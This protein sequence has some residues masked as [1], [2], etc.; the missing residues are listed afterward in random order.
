MKPTPLIAAML[1]VLVLGAGGCASL[2]PFSKKA[3]E[4]VFPEDE[5]I[6]LDTRKSLAE[7]RMGF[8]QRAFDDPAVEE[9]LG[10]EVISVDIIAN[11]SLGSDRWMG[12]GGS[13]GMESF[14]LTAIGADGAEARI[15][16]TAENRGHGW[17]ATGWRVR[18]A[19]APA[20]QEGFD[21]EEELSIPDPADAVEPA[22]EY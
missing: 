13:R 6:R 4:E 15:D 3:D 18:P 17:E 1:A 7:V 20:A 9:L 22:I 21:A 11:A 12:L 19:P 8:T 14:V 2:N 16:A 5:D 10:S